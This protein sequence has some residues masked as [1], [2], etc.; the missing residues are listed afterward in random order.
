MD[1]KCPRDGAPLTL[2]Q[3]HGIEVDRC[4]TCGG[5]WYEDEEL[6]ELEATVSDEEHRI[7]TIDYAKRDSELDCPVCNQRMRAFNYRAYNLELDAC[8][9]EHGFWLDAGESARI[10]EVM[11]ERVQGLRRSHS[12]QKAWQRAKGRGGDG[13]LDQLRRLFRR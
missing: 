12:A 5:A 10:R 1:L 2:G 6:V 11:K 13:V 4:P 7:G 3:E 8:T 9:Q